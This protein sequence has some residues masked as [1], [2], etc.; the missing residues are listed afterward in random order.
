MPS[1]AMLHKLQSKDVAW[2]DQISTFNLC[3]PSK[4]STGNQKW[5]PCQLLV[6]C[7]AKDIAAPAPPTFS[8]SSEP[9]GSAIPYCYW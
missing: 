4:A 7:A 5:R 1:K 9:P 2:L 8:A 6:N 3:P